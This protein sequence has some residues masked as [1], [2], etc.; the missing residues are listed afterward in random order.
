MFFTLKENTQYTQYF[1]GMLYL[2]YSVISIGE[3]FLCL[4]NVPD[5]LH[6]I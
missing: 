1:Q 3:F 4:M 5:Y 6:Q 2:V